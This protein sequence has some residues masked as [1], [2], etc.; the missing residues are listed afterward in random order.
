MEAL[1]KTCPIP[2][3]LDAD[4]LN[5]ISDN[6][7]L[8]YLLKP[9]LVLTPHPGEFKRLT[10]VWKDDLDKIQKQIQMAKHHK[11]YVVLKGANTSI[12]T[13]E[14]KIYFNSTGNPGMAKGGSGDVL[15][16]VITT[17]L[18]QGYKPDK[19][20]LL[21]VYA[22]GLAGDEAASQ[23]GQTGMN[24]EDIINYLPKAFASLEKN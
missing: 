22:H 4:A 1:L 14:G 11:V 5:I 15:T 3:V 23:I 24:A 19:A 13:P 10:G 21:G 8:R 9:N 18:A 12:A 7:S 20:V 17:L 16:G 2:L 6:Y